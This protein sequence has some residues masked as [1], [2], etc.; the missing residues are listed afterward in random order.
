[1]REKMTV[2]F[3]G[4]A[5]AFL[6]MII[7]EWGAQ[8]D[9]FKGSARKADEIGKVNGISLLNKDYD[10]M[11]QE[12]R[13]Q[14]LQEEGKTN[15]TEAEEN[16]IREKAWD[17]AVMTKLLQEKMDEYGV[18]V[19]NQEVREFLLYNPPDFLRR[20]FMDSATHQFNQAAYFQALNDP[21]NDTL[22][23]KLSAQMREELKKQKLSSLLQISMRTT[24]SEM[25]ERYENTNAKATFEVIRIKPTKSAKEFASTVTEEEIKKYYEDHTYQYKRDEGRKVKFVIFRELPTAKDSALLAERIEGLKKKW[26]AMPLN[27]SDSTVAEL[28]RDYTEQPVQPAVMNPPSALNQYS[29]S[30]EIINGAIGSVYTVAGQG[31]IKAMRIMDVRDSGDENYHAKSILI[32]FGNP[33]NKDSAKALATKLMADI[34][35]GADFADIAKKYSQD[36]SARNGGDMRWLAPKLYL[37]EF[38]AAAMK[39]PIGQLEGPIETVA[40]YHIFQVLGRTRKNLKLAT[41]SITPRSSSTTQKMVLQ[42][43]NLFHEKAKKEGFDQAAQTSNLRVQSD[44]PPIT[45]K[46][47][48]LFGY[49]PWTNYLFEL[50]AGDITAPV[51]IPAAKLVVVAQVTESQAEGIKPLDSLIKDQIKNVIAKRKA[52]EA[53][54]PR[55][56]EIRGMLNPGDD[57]AKIGAV[58]TNLKPFTVSAG[59]AESVGGLGTEYSVNIAAFNMKPGEISQPIMGDAGYYIIKLLDLKQADK[60]MFEAQKTKQFET[61]SQEK[62]QRFFGQWLENLKSKATIVDYRSHSR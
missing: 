34:H 24:R 42:Q 9:C 31:V 33:Q 36:Q 16:E 22:V 40:G 58:D 10:D 49:R 27:A 25:W 5:C 19:T 37:P 18:V 52:I 12:L 62:Q 47:Q 38:E 15:L 13:Q 41:I 11:F 48:P 39:A 2:I 23:A 30:D 35:A 43:A 1:M 53:M 4:L 6:L 3:V 45:R 26:A 28:A 7:F 60:Q 51:R 59:P 57:L 55:A 54:A 46:G 44:V 32:G 56:K 61:L 50:S 20:N 17:Q 8:G 14:K 21:H 29:N